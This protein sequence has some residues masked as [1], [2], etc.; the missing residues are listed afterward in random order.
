MENSTFGTMGTKTPANLLKQQS[1]EKNLQTSTPC[2]ENQNILPSHS[3]MHELILNGSGI[4]SASNSN[5]NLSVLGNNK[6]I[7]NVSASHNPNSSNDGISFQRVKKAFY[8]PADELL[9]QKEN[10][11]QHLKSIDLSK[12]SFPNENKPKTDYTYAKSSSYLKECKDQANDNIEMP[13][14]CRRPRRSPQ[15]SFNQSASQS[16]LNKTDSPPTPEESLAKS[17]ENLKFYEKIKSFVIPGADKTLNRSLGREL[18]DTDMNRPPARLVSESS[19]SVSTGS[20]FITTRS[21]IY[22]SES[23]ASAPPI[24]P[25]QTLP[26][27]KTSSKKCFYGFPFFLLLLFLTP[28]FLYGLNKID[29]ENNLYDNINENYLEKY[30]NFKINEEKIDLYRMEIN[31]LSNNMKQFFENFTNYFPQIFSM[32][33]NKTSLI[34]EKM[35]DYKDATIGGF[36]VVKN[37]LQKEA[38][39]LTKSLEDI[40]ERVLY[41]TMSSDNTKLNDVDLVN[42]IDQI[43]NYTLTLMSNKLA[44][45]LIE[46]KQSYE[47]ELKQ[48]KEVLK[49]LDSRY[50]NLVNQIQK[51]DLEFK[52]NS[53]IVSFQKIE[54]YINKSFYLYN[55]DKT[56]MTDFASESVGGSIMFT[57]CTE[58]YVDNS[59]WI[60]VMNLPITRVGVSPRVVIQGSMQPGNCWAFKGSKGD[61]FIKLAARITPTSFSLEHIPKELSLTGLIDSAP[62]NFSVYGYESKD[63]IN[64]DVKLLLGNYRYDN[65]SINTLQ[66]FSVQNHYNKP[67]SVVE[68][69]IES[70]SGNKEFTCLYKFRVHGKLYK[71]EQEKLTQGQTNENRNE[72]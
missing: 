35:I 44:D 64:D 43:F 46:S 20:A 39:D 52:D 31:R 3:S 18:D 40:K 4:N 5:R 66:F 36:D 59:R 60:T 27:H 63:Y 42:K 2:H 6:N 16:T 56:G 68:L 22:Q 19:S 69:K 67:I 65:E 54:E 29:Q 32:V 37:Y 8:E 71:N 28:F 26:L 57:K 58:D 70:N 33:K 7:N 55:A 1:S 30:L 53:P 12:Y 49:E 38:D 17:K 48:V 24:Q 15:N 13:N 62:Q 21:Q 61:L 25:I 23:T 14:L 10:M 50:K 72:F 11:L 51:K 47:S 9:K 41:E 34:T 45:Q